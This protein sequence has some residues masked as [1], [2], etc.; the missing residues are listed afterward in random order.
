M[1]LAGLLAVPNC[2]IS[3]GVGDTV[4]VQVGVCVGVLVGV[5]VGVG[6]LVAVAVGVRVGVGLL[7]GVGMGV[8]VG[9]C[10]GVDV[11]VGVKVWVG[12]TVDVGVRVGVGELV[13]VDVAVAVGVS[14]GVSVGVAVAVGNGVGVGFGVLH[15]KTL[16]VSI[17][18]VRSEADAMT[19]GCKK[20]DRCF[21]SNASC[22]LGAVFLPQATAQ[23]RDQ[24]ARDT[25]RRAS[26]R[27][28]LVGILLWGAALNALFRL[29]QISIVYYVPAALAM[30][31]C[32][33]WKVAELSVVDLRMEWR[34]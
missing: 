32:F 8:D 9:V 3:A 25:G 5:R 17:A 28:R 33:G 23:A 20:N 30:G 2:T 14:V 1:H 11:G 24:E 16:P 4:G 21:T 7:V 22:R 34:G 18:E 27:S 12:V 15:A 13:D 26:K 29:W 31:V 10:V 19:T 6:V